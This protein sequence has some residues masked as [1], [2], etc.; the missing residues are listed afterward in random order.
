M[1]IDSGANTSYH[2]PVVLCLHHPPAASSTGSD[3]INKPVSLK[4]RWDKGNMLEYLSHE[5]I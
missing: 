1:I 5:R 3:A 2:M 4:A